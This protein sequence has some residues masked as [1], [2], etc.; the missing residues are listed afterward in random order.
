MRT[1]SRFAV[2]FAAGLVCS[3]AAHAQPTDRPAAF[4]QAINAALALSPG[5]NFYEAKLENDDGVW[6]FD[7]ELFNSGGTLKTEYEID[8]ST[9]AVLKNEVESTTSEEQAEFLAIAALLGGAGVTP[10]QAITAATPRTPL[11]AQFEDMEREIQGGALVY[12]FEFTNNVRVL[13][14]AS[15]GAPTNPG[16]PSPTPNPSDPSVTAI[17]QA[18]LARYPG[19]SI[20]EVEFETGDNRWEVK[21]LT[22]NGTQRKLRISITGVIISDDLRNSSKEDKADDRLKLNGANGATITLAQAATIALNA[23]P[24][25]TVVKTEWEFEH[26]VAVIKVDLVDAGGPRTILVN[27]R[28]GAIVSPTPKPTKPTDPAAQIGLGAAINSALTANPGT[29]AI[30]VELEPEGGRQFYKVRTLSITLPLRLRESLV[31]G[32]T[33]QVRSTALLPMS[34]EFLSTAR[35]IRN[36]IGPSTIT[37]Q[38][39]AQNALNTLGDGVVEKIEL[40]PE[41]GGLVYRV[42][43]R[44]GEKVFELEIN[45]QSGSVT[46]R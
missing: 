6:L 16:N 7:I 12:K 34:T 22:A 17:I 33:A 30:S 32:K 39:A 46:P 36:R 42:D 28:T 1:H 2:T 19:A 3:L 31:D 25:A 4:T 35:Q 26:G 13:I 40:E 29:I 5:L 43:V 20:L 37:F 38:T 23:A 14:S 27:A 18:A 10:S 41:D 8:A 21:L 9:F 45:G 24:G 11:G 15:T 44:V